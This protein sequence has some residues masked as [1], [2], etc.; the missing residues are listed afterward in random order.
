M[1]HLDQRFTPAAR[2][3]AEVR[4]HYEIV[5]LVEAGDGEAAASMARVRTSEIED[6]IREHDA[7]PL[8]SG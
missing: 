1:S 7:R 6:F 2:H 8:V 4:T 3:L 5:R